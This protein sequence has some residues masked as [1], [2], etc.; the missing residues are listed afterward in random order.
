MIDEVLVS[1]ALEYPELLCHVP[2][3]LVVVGLERQ[4]LHGHD[5]AS[6]VVDGR[7]HL[8]ESALE[9]ARLVNEEKRLCHQAK[10]VKQSLS[11][12]LLH[13]FCIWVAMA[14]LED[15]G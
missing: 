1:D 13:F 2:E 15:T 4:L 12:F 3:R 10:K 14:C 6:L 9:E 5:V 11:L 8:A 7:V